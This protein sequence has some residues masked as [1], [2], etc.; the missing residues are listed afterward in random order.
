M[1]K[2]KKCVIIMLHNGLFGIDIDQVR[3]IERL[4]S[5]T[6]IPQTPPYVKGITN[7]R[8]NIIPIIDLRERLAMESKT[9]NEQT[10]L[11]VVTVKGKDIG[12]IVDAANEVIDIAEE[13]IQPTPTVN[14]NK[15]VDFLYGIAKLENKIVILLDVEKLLS[16]DD[17]VHL[18]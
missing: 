3:S 4:Q 1:E 9:N 18:E 12:L 10:R 16:R 2:H 8:G 17:V 6:V 11:V 13:Q 15:D 14:K 7:L 5:I